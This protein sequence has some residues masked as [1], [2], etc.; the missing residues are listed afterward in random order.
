VKN[1]RKTCFY[2]TVAHGNIFL[3]NTQYTCCSVCMWWCCYR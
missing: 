2:L 1:Y 3:I